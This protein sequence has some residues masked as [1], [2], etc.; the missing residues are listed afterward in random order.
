M[1]SPPPGFDPDSVTRRR[2]QW[3]EMQKARGHFEGFEALHLYDEGGSD[4][5]HAFLEQSY[6]A[7]GLHNLFRVPTYCDWLMDKLDLVQT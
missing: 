2:A 7:A 1:P 4:E 3:V 5:C 6:G